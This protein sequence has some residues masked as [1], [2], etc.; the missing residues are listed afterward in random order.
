MNKKADKT[1][2]DANK[3][4][5]YA[6]MRDEESDHD[7]KHEHDDDDDDDDD[8]DVCPR[9]SMCR[10]HCPCTTCLRARAPS[11]AALFVAHAMFRASIA[12]SLGVNGD[13]DIVHSRNEGDPG[14]YVI[15]R[16]RTI[17][18]LDGI[19]DGEPCCNHRVVLFVGEDARWER[20]AVATVRGRI[21]RSEW[22]EIA[23][24]SCASQG[25]VVWALAAVKQNEDV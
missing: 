6:E 1:T 5:M 3:G 22:M 2:E 15:V 19:F 16:G 20:T 13:G 7:H 10:T 24:A 18:S 12:E 21:A 14:T 23:F 11:D 4:Q 17:P 8:D 25:R 9:S